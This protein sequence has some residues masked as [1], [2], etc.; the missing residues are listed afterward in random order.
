MLSGQ[1]VVSPPEIEANSWVSEE[2]AIFG[3]IVV[4]D[5]RLALTL[6]GSDGTCGCVCISDCTCDPS[7]LLQ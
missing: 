1:K 3:E 2:E 7:C 5:A 6:G 4:A